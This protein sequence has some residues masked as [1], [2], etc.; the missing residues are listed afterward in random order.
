MGAIETCRLVVSKTLNHRV[1]NVTAVYDRAG[2]DV[3]KRE[4]LAPWDRRIVGIVNR[5]A[6]DK[7]V[8]IR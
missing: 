4:A 6:F 5:Q 7:I 3:D 8:A 1:R 2:Y